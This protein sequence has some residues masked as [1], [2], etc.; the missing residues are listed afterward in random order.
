MSRLR[1]ARE[2]LIVDSEKADH[3]SR[4]AADR[5]ERAK[6]YVALKELPSLFH[7]GELLGQV[8]THHAKIDL[9]SGIGGIRHRAQLIDD[10]SEETDIA[11]LFVASWFEKLLDHFQERLHPLGQRTGVFEALR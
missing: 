2:D 4:N 3:A 6:S 11:E 10:R 9:R 1:P 7:G 5:F 8:V